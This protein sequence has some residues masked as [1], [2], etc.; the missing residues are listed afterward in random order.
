MTPPPPS[1]KDE[2]A[3]VE[4]KDELSKISML[5]GLD[6]EE[7]TDCLLKP[8]IKVTKE[9]AN[10]AMNWLDGKRMSAAVS[11]LHHGG[12]MDCSTV[13]FVVDLLTFLCRSRL[14]GVALWHW[15]SENVEN[16]TKMLGCP[17]SSGAHD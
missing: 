12:R 11:F 14:C 1:G 8:K 17:T 3:V 5:L 2:Q 7:F 9:P 16:W 15:D 10:G 6:E 13:A 4:T